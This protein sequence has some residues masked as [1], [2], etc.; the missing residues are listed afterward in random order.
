MSCSICYS[1]LTK[2]ITCES[3]TCE[4][5]TCFKCFIDY[6]NVCKKNNTFVVCVNELCGN[7][8]SYENMKKLN[9]DQEYCD[10][11]VKS[12]HK[13][14][15]F[16]SIQLLKEERCKNIINNMP[17][18]LELV[19]K[20]SHSLKLKS[21]KQKQ[22]TKKQETCDK[23]VE[24]IENK[25]SILEKFNSHKGITPL[26]KQ[27]LY[28]MFKKFEISKPVYFDDTHI[29]TM[30]KNLGSSNDNEKFTIL[31]TNYLSNNL[32]IKNFNDTN[33]KLF[34]LLAIRNVDTVEIKKTLL[35]N[36]K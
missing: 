24:I 3:K 7:H 21:I 1:E 32:K 31:L 2:Y 35:N 11:V 6:F 13:N 12:Y 25:Y 14:I 30:Y 8:Y 9:L 16:S 10:L 26:V 36:L 20:V 15:D 18:A 22:Y 23:K 19:A 29:K 34:N 4:S 33:E 5:K 27:E 28:E 17:K